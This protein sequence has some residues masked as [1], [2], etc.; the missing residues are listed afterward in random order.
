MAREIP[1]VGTS[2]ARRKPC[3]RCGA[4]GLTWTVVST[5]ALQRAW[6]LFN[7]DGTQHACHGLTTGMQ[8]TGITEEEETTTETTIT[9]ASAEETARIHGLKRPALRTEYIAR[10]PEDRTRSQYL[11]MDAM[12][13]ALITGVRAPESAGT[14]APTVQISPTGDGTGG[15]AA[16]LAAL[17]QRISAG[18]M[19][20]QR[21]TTIA[22]READAAVKRGA[23]TARVIE[24]RADG[25]TLGK[26]EGHTHY[27]LPK[28]VSALA[29]GC[30]VFLYGAAGGGKTTVARQAA[31]AWAADFFQLSVGP[32]TRGMRLVGYRSPTTGEYVAGPLRPYSCKRSVV[33]L[34]EIDTAHPSV[35]PEV[36]ALL[37]NGHYTWADDV[38]TAIHPHFRVIAGANTIGRGADG[39]YMRQPIDGASLDRF[40]FIEFTYDENLERA[41]IGA[42]AKSGGPTARTYVPADLNA[43]A[44][45]AW[46]DRVADYRRAVTLSKVRLIVGPRATIYGARLLSAGWTR[47][48]VEDAVI[49]RG[50]SQDDRSRVLANMR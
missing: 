44:L 36:N 47:D 13:T 25:Q 41:L 15:D 32:D 39:V 16:S 21:V 8:N 50:A 23:N 18:A 28:I 9:A 24:V 43:A 34:D 37:A 7:A 40:A 42:P 10:F 17:I 22:K 26:V 1:A 27:L 4:T 12:R 33:L 20:E 29:A 46:H 11:S 45:G 35:L 14:N 38:E 6:R 49:W 5:Y 19:D 31:Q 30:H 3:D 2:A 48:E